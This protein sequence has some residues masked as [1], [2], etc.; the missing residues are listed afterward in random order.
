VEILDNG[1]K[2]DREGRAPAD[3]HIIMMG[4]H[5][6]GI[7]QSHGRAESAADAV[8]LGG[9][10]ILFTDCET[11]PDRAAVVAAAALQGECGRLHP[12][13]IGNGDEIRPL[14]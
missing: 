9:G 3:K 2:I 14:P 1:R 6:Y 7:H 8:A 11:D 10:P 13:A 5:R 12:R 4:R